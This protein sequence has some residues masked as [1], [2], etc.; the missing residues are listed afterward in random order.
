MQT[1]C[2]ADFTHPKPDSRKNAT[3]KL[4]KLSNAAERIAYADPLFNKKMFKIKY[5]KIS[6]GNAHGTQVVR[7]GRHQRDS[8][9]CPAKDRFHE[10]EHVPLLD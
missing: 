2:A 1:L 6:L 7:K 3:Q 9:G 4:R 8:Q 10:I 5:L